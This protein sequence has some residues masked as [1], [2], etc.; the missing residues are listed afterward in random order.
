MYLERMT[1][2][3]VTVIV[4]MAKAIVMIVEVRLFERLR[5]SG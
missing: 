3:M 2:I 5:Q 1:E 4:M